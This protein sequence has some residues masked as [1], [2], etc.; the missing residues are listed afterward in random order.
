MSEQNIALDVLGKLSFVEHIFKMYV[1]IKYCMSR[2]IR[3]L[4]LF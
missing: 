1:F 2:V 3:L 4:S